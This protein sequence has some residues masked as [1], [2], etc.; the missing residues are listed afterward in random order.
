MKTAHLRNVYQKIGRFNAPGP[1]VDG[2]GLIHDGT[3]DTVANFLRMDGFFF[4]GK[5]EEEKDVTRRLLHNYIMSFDTGMAPAVGRQLTIA[6]HVQKQELG[7]LDLLM[8]R[9]AAGD[10]DLTAR[11][12]ER[13]ALRGWLYR[14]GA[15][16]ADASETEPLPLEPL[17]NRYRQSGEPITFT[18][19]PPGDGV[20]SA[21]DR[22]LDGR[23]DGDERLARNHAAGAKNVP[24]SPK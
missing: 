5:T 20:R 23:L 6:D 4:P 3:F 10:C 19:V 16:H 22:D 7:L 24:P 17:L 1:Q 12:W 2:Y 18:C 13:A 21:L 14:A 9:A 8:T 15:F 11:G